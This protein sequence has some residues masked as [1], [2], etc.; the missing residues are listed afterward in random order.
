MCYLWWPRCSLGSVL[1]LRLEMSGTPSS[2][3]SSQGVVS[4]GVLFS[5]GVL[6]LCGVHT[7]Q[8]FA[9][10]HV[11]RMQQQSVWSAEDDTDHNNNNVL[12][13]VVAAPDL[14]IFWT[15]STLFAIFRRSHESTTTAAVAHC[16]HPYSQGEGSTPLL[17]TTTAPPAAVVSY[18]EGLVDE[19]L[20]DGKFRVARTELTLE[21]WTSAF[22]EAR[23]L[24][25]G[26]HFFVYFAFIFLPL[27]CGF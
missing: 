18:T 22:N 21:L 10:V 25:C 12:L 1:R 14:D 16:Y 23:S 11:L 24:K 3:S 6:I 20:R 5:V 26:R 15:S 27:S 8:D 7:V 4:R 19:L 17:I 2:S 9:R 13:C